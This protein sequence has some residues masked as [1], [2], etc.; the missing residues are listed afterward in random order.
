MNEDCTAVCEREKEKEGGRGVVAEQERGEF[1]DLSR[2]R[3]WMSPWFID[4]GPLSDALHKNGARLKARTMN[5]ER[6]CLI[7]TI[8]KVNEL[9]F[10]RKYCR[11]LVD[12]RAKTNLPRI[13]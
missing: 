12:R 11:L 8:S 7:S 6:R 10:P 4:V 3:K 13:L 1:T 2:V 5:F 9:V